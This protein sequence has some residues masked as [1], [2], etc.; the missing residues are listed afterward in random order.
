MSLAL[1]DHP[2]GAQASVVDAA[3]ALP[4][5]RVWSPPKWGHPGAARRPLCSRLGT[6]A[7]QR[8]ESH[9]CLKLKLVSCGI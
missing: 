1:F 9:I 6:A 8:A 2:Q 3:T 7:L 5:Q 4:P